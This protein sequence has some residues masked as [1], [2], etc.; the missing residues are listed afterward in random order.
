MLE[1]KRLVIGAF[2]IAFGIILPIFFHFVSLTGPIFLPM[3]L[4][5]LLGGLLLG[6]RAG[7]IIGI[8]TP[9][10]SSFLTGMPPLAILPLITVEL[11]VYGFFSGWLYQQRSCSCI[12][13]LAIAML[14][15][16]VAVGLTLC[17]F[18]SVLGIN[19]VPS[20]YVLAALIKGVPGIICQLLIIPVLL[21]QLE[22][23]V[24]E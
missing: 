12:G 19:T 4:P 15:G 7:L 14:A 8:I 10:A 22:R 13:S 20:V 16:R 3:H 5:V 9:V 11:G 2:F 24:H 17:A 6:R 1:T 21:R 18:G 23:M